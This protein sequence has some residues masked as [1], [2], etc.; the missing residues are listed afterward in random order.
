MRK[1]MA[2]IAALMMFAG[3]AAQAA[4]STVTVLGSSNPFLAGQ[5]AGTSCCGGDAAPGQSPVLVTGTLTSS[6]T[7][8]FS[9]AGGFNYAGGTPSDSLDGDH[10]G[11]NLDYPFSMVADYGTGISG[12]TNVNVDGLVGV[13]TTDTQ[14]SGAAPAPMD[15]ATGGNSG[16]LADASYAPGLDQIFWIGDGLTGTGTGSVQQFLVPT[17]ATRLYLGTVDGEGW[18]NNTGVGLVTVSGLTT[19]GVPEPAT[20]AMMML[21]VFGLGAMLRARRKAEVA[22]LAA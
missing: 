2:A 12:P 19:G 5:P 13:F 11:Q 20:W 7:L 9:G 16:G 10:T 1:S 3:G 21:G 6:A 22:A 17:G 14:P 18:A 8:T 15:Y 4:S